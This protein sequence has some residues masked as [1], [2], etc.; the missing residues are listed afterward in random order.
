MGVVE[1]VFEHG[2]GGRNDLEGHLF[3]D[4]RQRQVE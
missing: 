1:D 3:N 4:L 2:T